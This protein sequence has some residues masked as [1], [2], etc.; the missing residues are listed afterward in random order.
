MISQWFDET[1]YAI[2]VI[3]CSKKILRRKCANRKKN[4]V[5][6]FIRLSA[7]Y[8]KKWMLSYALY[9]FSKSHRRQC[10]LQLA[11]INDMQVGE[12]LYISAARIRKDNFLIF[13]VRN[14]AI[15]SV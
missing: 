9:K 14:V 15:S 4:R 6:S 3:W 1:D 12:E 2:N 10:K 13:P 11:N 7:K 5:Q 8:E